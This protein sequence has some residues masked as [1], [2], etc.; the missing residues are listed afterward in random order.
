[1]NAHSA[2]SVCASLGVG[3]KQLAELCD[4]IDVAAAGA[5]IALLRT[6]ATDMRHCFEATNLEFA[7]YTQQKQRASL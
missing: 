2:A 1:M 7:A 4:G 6:L 3:A 5:Q